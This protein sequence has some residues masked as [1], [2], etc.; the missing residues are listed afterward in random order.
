RRTASPIARG[1]K[2]VSTAAW[3]AAAADPTKSHVAQRRLMTGFSSDV[4]SFEWLAVAWFSAFTLAAP[5][6]AA[7]PRRRLAVSLLCAALV[8]LIGWGA[9]QSS[10]AVRAWLPHAYLVLGYWVPGLLVAAPSVPTRFEAWLLRSD[11]AVRPRLPPVPRPF[12]PVVELAYLL[13]YPL[14]PAAFAVVW[15][16]G[17]AAD[18]SRFWIAVLAS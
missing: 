7:A 8:L 13:C 14:V 15:R 18:V 17:N 1:V 9:P 16:E 5:F 6:T 2:G 11:A 4:L 12:V 10:A 3:T